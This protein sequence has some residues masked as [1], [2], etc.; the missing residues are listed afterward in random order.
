[1]Y[2]YIYN[3]YVMYIHIHNRLCLCM[4]NFYPSQNDDAKHTKQAYHGKDLSARS[5]EGG[6]VSVTNG[7]GSAFAVDVALGCWV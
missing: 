3:M 5:E 6:F 7:V 4:N 2:I 1:M